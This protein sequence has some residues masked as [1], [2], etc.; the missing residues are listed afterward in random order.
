MRQNNNWS[1]RICWRIDRH[2][3]A[4]QCVRTTAQLSSD[5]A[6]GTMKWLC[7]C[8]DSHSSWRFRIAVFSDQECHHYFK[9]Q[10]FVI[11]DINIGIDETLLKFWDN[12]SFVVAY[13]DNRN[14]PKKRAWTLVESQIPVPF[15]ASVQYF[16]FLLNFW[17]VLGYSLL[18]KSSQ[19]LPPSS[20]P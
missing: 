5:N 9:S 10:N 2:C 8:S 7:G 6:I 20:L 12:K 14:K 3:N 15:M 16:H 17:F 1:I 11:F 4:S 19:P 18:L 13:N